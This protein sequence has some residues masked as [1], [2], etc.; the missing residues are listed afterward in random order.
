[1][2]LQ[3]NDYKL[4]GSNGAM[5]VY[6]KK[7]KT[8]YY[9]VMEKLGMTLQNYLSVFRETISLQTVTY[10]GKHLTKRLFEIH[11]QGFVYNNLNGSNIYVGRKKF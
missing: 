2:L 6:K 3:S 7:I 9:V 8:L 1:M 10:I 4:E 5:K 11:R